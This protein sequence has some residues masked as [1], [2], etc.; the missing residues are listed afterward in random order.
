MNFPS[1]SNEIAYQMIEKFYG[2]IK[3]QFELQFKFLQFK[4][5]NKYQDHI[6]YCFFTC[7][8]IISFWS[9]GISMFT[10]LVLSN[11][12]PLSINLPFRVFFHQPISK[13]LVIF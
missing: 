9:P 10:L 1:F 11:F 2:E 13:K 6:P 12:I 5:F 4:S 7:Q 3:E 8:C